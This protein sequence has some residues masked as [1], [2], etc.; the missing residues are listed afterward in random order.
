MRWSANALHTA[1]APLERS[2]WRKKKNFSTWLTKPT[3]PP[4][5]ITIYIHTSRT[6]RKKTSLSPLKSNRPLWFD[7]ELMRPN[8]M[9]ALWWLFLAPC[10][11]GVA[12]RSPRQAQTSSS[13]GGRL[14]TKAFEFPYSMYETFI[15]EGQANQKNF[16][17]VNIKT[18]LPVKYQMTSL[19]D[20][21]SQRLFNIDETTGDISTVSD[22]N[23]EFMPVHYFK[24][25][26]E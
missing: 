12:S 17:S 9:R 24:V 10:L 22:I 25:T 13:A 20:S 26:G 4:V 1:P 14:T 18:S 7:H 5:F 2:C 6:R 21:R 15:P 19:I 23:R 16:F 3:T 11:L 8:I